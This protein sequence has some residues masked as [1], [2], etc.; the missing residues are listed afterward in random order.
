MHSLFLIT[1]VKELLI[2]N[3]AIAK[4]SSAELMVTV[5]WGTIKLNLIYKE[6]LT[7]I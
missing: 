2:F 3:I 6:Y 1:T 7:A 5:F 4:K